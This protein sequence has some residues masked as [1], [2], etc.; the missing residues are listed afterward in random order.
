MSACGGPEPIRHR[1][2]LS[3]GRDVGAY[4]GFNISSSTD[5]VEPGQPLVLT[6]TLYSFGSQS[7]TLLDP[8]SLDIM[9]MRDAPS[10]PTTQSKRA[11]QSAAATR[12][13]GTTYTVLIDRAGSHH[14]I[15]A[16]PNG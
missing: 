1:S 10:A 11:H 5:C 4:L 7:I 2:T 16:G 15:V 12:A 3:T 14:A 6:L 8:P 9:L 13:I